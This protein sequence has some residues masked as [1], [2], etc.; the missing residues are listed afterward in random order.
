MCDEM[1]SKSNIEKIIVFVFFFFFPSFHYHSSHNLKIENKRHA[2]SAFFTKR[3]ETGKS[4]HRQSN[5]IIK[6][7]NLIKHKFTFD[8]LS[9]ITTTFIY[10]HYFILFYFNFSYFFLLSSFFFFPTFFH[11]FFFFPFFN[12]QVH[13]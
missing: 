6:V 11:Y 12:L 8:S 2:E 4:S 10:F 9:L 13:T 1:P 5:V 7:L 3:I